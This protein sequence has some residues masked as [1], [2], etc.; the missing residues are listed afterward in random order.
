MI[1]R[2]S[3]ARTPVEL[4]TESWDPDLRSSSEVTGYHV[5]AS[6][7]DIGYVH[8]FVVDEESWSI[9]YLVVDTGA[10]LPG[11]QVLVSPHWIS[12]ISF[13]TK[14]VTLN[15]TQAQIHAAPEYTSETLLSRDYETLLH[16]YYGKKEYWEDEI[17]P[18]LIT[19]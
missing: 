17:E 6:D 16:K 8:D 7:G 2:D 14:I 3:A 13:G 19:K 1:I 12:H 18:V 15:L 9:R 11:K 4:P 10:I 5:S